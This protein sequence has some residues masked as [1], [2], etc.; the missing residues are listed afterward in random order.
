MALIPF[1][2]FPLHFLHVILATS[3]MDTYFQVSV[4]SLN[5]L[6][7]RWVGKHYSRTDTPFFGCAF[8]GAITAVLATLGDSTRYVMSFKYQSTIPIKFLVILEKYICII[9]LSSLRLLLIS[10][11]AKILLDLMICCAALLTR[12]GLGSV[13]KR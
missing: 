3:N 13:P 11:T 7:P 9:K 12:Y 6:I 5:G 2:V 8:I 10:A 1:Y 4:L